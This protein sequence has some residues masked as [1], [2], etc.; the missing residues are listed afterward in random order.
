[1]AH[2][3]AAPL[4][5]RLPDPGSRIAVYLVVL[6][7]ERLGAFACRRLWPVV[8]S[9]VPAV[10]GQARRTSGIRLLGAAQGPSPRRTAKRRRQ[11][12]AQACL[13]SFASIAKVRG[14]GEAEAHRV[15]L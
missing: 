13:T 2:L 15:V 5:R 3:R 12:R 7:P 6:Q 9:A 11:E 1:M 14:R 10:A 8:G 4:A